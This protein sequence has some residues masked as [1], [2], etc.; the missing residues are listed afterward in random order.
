MKSW[1]G[2]GDGYAASRFCRF[3]A[4]LSAH[5]RRDGQLE[6]FNRPEP[7]APPRTRCL[8]GTLS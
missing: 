7:K 4:K 6:P 5:Q 2:G 3:A 8:A 1:T